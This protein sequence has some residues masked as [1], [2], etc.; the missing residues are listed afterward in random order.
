[1]EY[2][3][4]NSILTA[5]SIELEAKLAKTTTGAKSI[6]LKAVDP[7]FERH[8]KGAYIPVKISGNKDHPAFKLDVGKVF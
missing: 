4:S 7:L 8:G 6:L 3:A 1:M 2:G 5:R